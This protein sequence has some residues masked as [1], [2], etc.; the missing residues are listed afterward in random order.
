MRDTIT[1]AGPFLQT[2]KSI[3][4]LEK[5]SIQNSGMYCFMCKISRGS[6]EMVGFVVVAG[7]TAPL[8]TEC[9]G[10]SRL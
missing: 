3:I 4:N 1:L 6:G 2:K 9:Q 7:V 10:A 8:L 5:Y